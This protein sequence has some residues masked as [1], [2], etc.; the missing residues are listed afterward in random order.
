MKIYLVWFSLLVS[1]KDF[2]FVFLYAEW[3]LEFVRLHFWR[4]RSDLRITSENKEEKFLF[5]LIA[6]YIKSDKEVSSRSLVF[7]YPSCVYLVLHRSVKTSFSKLVRR[8]RGNEQVAREI[9]QT[10]KK[11]GSSSMRRTLIVIISNKL[12]CASRSACTRTSCM[13]RF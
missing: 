1:R 10:K 6:F 5:V 8:E 2:T 9:D 11:K 4:T 7:S 3:R 13:R 12:L